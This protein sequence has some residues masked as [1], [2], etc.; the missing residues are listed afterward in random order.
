MGCQE[1]TFGA[2]QTW[3]NDKKPNI[4][5]SSNPLTLL[6]YISGV[7]ALLLGLTSNSSRWLAVLLGGCGIALATI[8]KTILHD[9]QNLI[10]DTSKQIEN[11]VAPKQIPQDTINTE[12]NNSNLNNNDLA[13]SQLKDVFKLDESVEDD[14]SNSVSNK[15]I[16]RLELINEKL[17]AEKIISSVKSI[18]TR[19]KGKTYREVRDETY[20]E[21]FDIGKGLSVSIL[22]HGLLSKNISVNRWAVLC[23][24]S[25]TSNPDAE[26]AIIDNV[27]KNP[28]IISILSD[29]KKLPGNEH[30]NI[31]EKASGILNKI[32]QV[33]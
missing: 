2:I 11:K 10:Q 23:L 19:L 20:S 33:A 17:D 24:L 22:A 18:L 12:N 9:A 32:F 13:T 1:E 21:L 16:E 15:P 30:K 28:N 6:G 8:S 25:K 3:Q 26:K 7:S 27:A 29:Y 5:Q 14:E 31:S 4:I